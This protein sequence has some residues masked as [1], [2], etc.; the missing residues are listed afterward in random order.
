MAGLSRDRR[1]GL[2]DLV[3]LGVEDGAHEEEVGV[4]VGVLLVLDDVGVD[5]EQCR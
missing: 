5:G 1:R 4:L 3:R 2:P